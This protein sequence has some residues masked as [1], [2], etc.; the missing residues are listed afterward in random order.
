MAP[1]AYAQVAGL[2]GLRDSRAWRVCTGIALLGT[3]A[4]YFPLAARMGIVGLRSGD[5]S[6]VFIM[7]V[8]A[9][10]L[11]LMTPPA[12][13]PTQN[14]W[15]V[16]WGLFVTGLALRILGAVVGS[17]LVVKLSFPLLFPG[18]TALCF[19]WYAAMRARL[20]VLMLVFG[21]GLVTDLLILSF[22]HGLALFAAGTVHDLA[23]M[24][25]AGQGPFILSGTMILSSNRAFDV[26]AECSGTRWITALLILTVL[27]SWRTRLAFRTTLKLAVAILL[28]AVVGNVLRIYATLATVIVSGDSHTFEGIHSL[29]NWVM[30][31]C[32]ILL[33]PFLARNV[34]HWHCRLTGTRVMAFLIAVCFALT[35]VLQARQGSRVGISTVDGVRR[36]FLLVSNS[37]PN[38]LDWLLNPPGKAGLFRLPWLAGMLFHGNSVHML[39]NLIVLVLLGEVLRGSRLGNWRPMVPLLVG[40]AAGFV[41]GRM[42]LADRVASAGVNRVL[43]IGA[44]GAVSGLFGA[45]VAVLLISHRK[46]WQALFYVAVYGASIVAG[47]MSLK[48]PYLFSVSSHLAAAAAGAA[49]TVA[50]LLAA[51][52]N[53]AYHGMPDQDHGEHDQAGMD[54]EQRA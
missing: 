30:I 48:P 23:S 51:V 40:H 26:A 53:A 49:V 8:L 5:Y 3:I 10:A 38:T 14:R 41:V 7:P 19:G 37:L 4:G 39:T 11:Y 21:F 28:A 42:V 46:P 47:R 32:C 1:R 6:H 34:E 15:G 29:W 52:K 35:M 2:A 16:S 43:S 20:A 45:Y 17:D 13:G 27:V 36:P 44:S 25:L 18:A 31:V 12:A 24:T 9:L 54:D 22:S 33:L 50:M